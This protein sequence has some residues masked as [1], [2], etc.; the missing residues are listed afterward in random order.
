[1]ATGWTSLS[2]KDSDDTLSEGYASTFPHRVPSSSEYTFPRHVPSSSEYTLPRRVVSSSQ[3]TI[4]SFLVSPL[5]SPRLLSPRIAVYAPES[6]FP[7]ATSPGLHSQVSGYFSSGRG[8]PPSHIGESYSL[9]RTAETSN[10][11]YGDLSSTGTTAVQG[12]NSQSSLG[13]TTTNLDALL[14]PPYFDSPPPTATA[15]NKADFYSGPESTAC[16]VPVKGGW[17]P[18]WLRRRVLGVFLGGFGVM[19]VVGELLMWFLGT[20]DKAAR[21][22]GVWTF[23]PIIIISVMTMLWSRVEFQALQYTPWIILHQRPSSVTETRRR[24]AS[25]T[26][27][28]D[29]PGITS[30]EALT[31]A[32]RNRHHLVVASVTASILLRVQIVLS[33]GV[34]HAEINADGSR[35]LKVRL[36]TLHTMA[37]IFCVLSGLLLPMLYHA[38]SKHGITPRDP[39]S[40]AGTAALL[41]SSRALL[42]RLTGTGNMDMKAVAARLAES[43]YTTVIHQ[44]GRKPERM[45]QL[46]QPHEGPTLFDDGSAEGKKEEICVYRPWTMETIAQIVI[47]VVSVLLLCGLFIVFGVRGNGYGFDTTDSMYIFWT[48]LPTLFLVGLGLSLNRIDIDNRRLAPF[49]KLTGQKRRFRE[50]LGLTYLNEFGLETAYKSFRHKD[51][52]VFLRKLMAMLGWLMPI[53]TAGLFA[54]AELEQTADLHLQPESWFRSTTDSSG[55]S[56]DPTI[57]GDVLLAATPHYPAWT[58]EDMAFPELTLEDHGA[59]WPLPNT[60][61]ITKIPATRASLSCETVSLSLG[62]GAEL[63][64][65]PIDGDS[66][67]AICQKGL[68]NTGFVASSCSNMTMKNPINYIWGSCDSDGTITVLTCNETLVEVDV[69]VTFRTET[70]TIDTNAIPIPDETSGRQA[71]LKLGVPG[72]YEALE[73][74]GSTD[75]TLKGLDG[76]FRTLVMSRLDVPIQR[77]LLPE[78]ANAVIQVI[79]L[80]HGIIRAQIFDSKSVRQS[81]ASVDSPAIPASIAASVEYYIPRLKQSKAQTYTLAVLLILTLLLGALALRTRQRCTLPKNPGSIAAQASLFADSTFW[82]RLPD[83]AEYLSDAALARCLRRRTFRLGWFA[84]GAARGG[85]RNG[86]MERNFGIGIVQDQGKVARVELEGDHVF[87]EPGEQRWTVG[88]MDPSAYGDIPLY[89]KA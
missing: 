23:G 63:E 76:F 28:L 31:S 78:R 74:I 61:L 47:I 18:A 59:H 13:T 89:E 70:L 67:T 6:E 73:T 36:G 30:F 65:T 39:T 34:F 48:S 12:E 77:L 22:D 3:P 7:E 64:C 27:L 15:P 52:A 56:L 71:N 43:W 10:I 38:P 14:D 42:A 44:K 58:W 32:F 72:M 33:T 87:P 55:E 17:R 19:A 2:L 60:Q 81:F 24:Q 1:M 84:G 4:S 83:G 54:I 86:V 5:S 69:Q 53:F 20:G 16:E 25:R 57:I 50:S 45:F 51:W 82:W 37:G 85:G 11:S 80:Q 62:A 29:Y 9:P 49:T 41:A 40:V 66:D 88:S 46:K 75:N 79:K 26:I 8:T 68:S 35:N 21:I